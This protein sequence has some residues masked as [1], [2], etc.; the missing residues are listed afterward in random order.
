MSWR[1]KEPGHQQPWY[2]LW[3]NELFRS[4]LIKGWNFQSPSHVDILSD[5]FLL[6]SDTNTSKYQLTNMYKTLWY[7]VRYN[8]Y[9]SIQFNQHHHTWPKTISCLFLYSFPVS[10]SYPGF[11]SNRQHKQPWI[12]Q[13]FQCQAHSGEK[14]TRVGT[15]LFSFLIRHCRPSFTK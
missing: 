11:A 13:R 15:L 9:L 14:W 5:K 12:T 10:H 1:R 6:S 7:R 4:P 3:W 8:T 2:W